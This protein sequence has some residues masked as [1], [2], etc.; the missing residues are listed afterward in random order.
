M[1]RRRFEGT[2]AYA[3]RSER[4]EPGS[5]EVSKCTHD[6]I[7]DALVRVEIESEAGV[8]GHSASVP[9]PTSC[10]IVLPFFAVRRVVIWIEYSLLLDEDTGG[11]FGG[12]GAYATLK[13][14]KQRS[15]A[16]LSI[17]A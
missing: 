10:P 15:D 12:L 14:R 13:T 11:P 16:T 4:G 9:L 6:F 2:T 3:R 5:R 7:D 8:A 17:L 1:F